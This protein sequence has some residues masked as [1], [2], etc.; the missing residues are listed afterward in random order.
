M[1]HLEKHA[2]G[3]T[4]RQRGVQQL[5]GILED[6][7]DVFSG[8]D[9]RVATTDVKATFEGEDV[10]DLEDLDPALNM[11]MHLVNNVCE[12]REREVR[13]AEGCD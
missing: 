1:A 7:T 11:K 2:L 10:L 13:I 8:G 9:V 6:S 4:G 3:D 12:I 5:P